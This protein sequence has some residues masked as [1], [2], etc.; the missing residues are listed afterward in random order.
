MGKLRDFYGFTVQKGSNI[1][2]NAARLLV[3]RK[4]GGI[5]AEYN[6]KYSDTKNS[7]CDY[8]YTQSE[9]KR[10]VLIYIH[11]GGWVS[12]VK[13]LRRA[14]C[15]EFADRGFFVMNTHYDCAPQKRF[16]YQFG[17]LFKAIETLLDSAEKYNLDTSKIVLAGESAGAY[18][19]S[20]LAAIAKDNSL[21][22]KLGINFKYRDTFDVNACVL[23]NGAYDAKELAGIRF[24]NMKTFIYCY[25]GVNAKEILKNPDDERFEYFSPIKFIGSNFPPT[26]VGRGRHDGLD[27]ES[28]R[29]VKLFEKK[30]IKYVSFMAEGLIGIHGFCLAVNVKEGKRCFEEMFS[31]VKEELGV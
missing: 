20:Y 25:Y 21:Y 7:L 17:Q 24:I 16:P 4:K 31:F 1:L 29:L 5:T 11:G 23:L 8:Y 27:A 9:N 2:E 15:F 28:E 6:I 13:A 22:D 12:G 14:Y 30:G 19:A 18:F 26:V 3:R 10:P